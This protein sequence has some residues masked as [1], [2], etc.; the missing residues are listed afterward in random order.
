MDKEA[1]EQNRQKVIGLSRFLIRPGIRCANLASRCYRLVLGQVRSD[2][3][4][5]Y[6][7]KPLLVETFVDR[8]TYTGRSLAASNW[9]RIGQSQGRGRSSARRDVRSTSLKDVW[10]W[11]W[12]KDARV[13][14]QARPLPQILP[15]SLFGQNPE[16]SHWVEE[17]LDGLDLGHAKLD[18]R[19]INLLKRR[20]AHPDWSFYASFPSRNEASQAY[21]FLENKRADLEFENLLLPHQQSTRRRMAAETV[22]LLAQDTTALSYN[23]LKKTQ[24]LGPLG[25]DPKSGYGLL[26]HT[27]QGFR[28]DAIP[29]G[30]AWAQVWARPAQSDTAKRNQQSIDQ[31]ESGRW[32]DAYQAASTLAVAMPQTTILVAGDRESDVIDLYDR[33]Q[34]APPN[35]FYLVRA[36]HDRVLTSGEKLW[37]TLST[38]PVG[39]L[40]EVSV[41]RN[42]NRPA[43]LA[44][45]EIKWGQVEIV[46]PRVGCKNS[47]KPLSLSVI[48][49]TEIN[50]PTG[51]DPIEWVLLTDWKIDSFKMA[52]R[53]ICWYAL[54][55]GIECWHQVLKDGCGV[56]KR[57]FK[58]AEA[59]KRSLVLDM[60][61]AWRTLMLCRLG[62][63]HPT[64]PAFC[65][66][67]PEEL[68]ILE[69]VAKKKG[70]LKPRLLRP[71][72]LACL[73]STP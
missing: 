10:V 36:Q 50:P 49:A 55:W 9:L 54:R 3:M 46:P 30:C 42:K 23:Q 65:F 52:L 22:V 44:T 31:K 61:I 25:N 2:W 32:V 14:L 60:I 6:G 67:S 48:S 41:S 33:G 64:L 70:F 69:T 12:E 40:Q 17:E 15:R 68:A 20:W 45:L 57:Q 24:G 29:L 53:I 66:Y 27:L 35:L 5:R 51:A 21:E 59:L 13:K 38:L 16:E 1:R 43:R 37:D 71:L 62:K 34:V 73:A 56:E 19:F 4:K 28:L 8:S 47:W 39:G 72:P 58:T 26:L 7:V 63:N 11:Q 18:Q